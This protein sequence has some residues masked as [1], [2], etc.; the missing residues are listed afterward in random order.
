MK[1]EL[2]QTA[3]GFR[4]TIT[5]YNG[6]VLATQEAP[7]Q[8]QAIVAAKYE[9]R[10]KEL[11]LNEAMVK[12]REDYLESKMAFTVLSECMWPDHPRHH[13]LVPKVKED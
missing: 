6:T 2:E 4:Y 9:L 10:T 8:A 3:V 7:T 11:A 12:A 5:G 13:K 1:I